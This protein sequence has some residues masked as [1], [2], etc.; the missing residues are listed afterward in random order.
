MNGLI[1][2]IQDEFN[3]LN[4][5]SMAEAYQESLRIEEKLL[6]KQQNVKRTSRYAR[7]KQKEKQVE[8]DES[9]FVVVEETAE[10][11]VDANRI[12]G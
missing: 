1:Y 2:A 8:D 5:H 3:V 9:S 4:F 7:G 10:K 11:G 6:R 12:H